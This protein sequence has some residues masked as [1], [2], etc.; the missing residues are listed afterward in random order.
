MSGAVTFLGHHG[1]GKRVSSAIVSG[2]MVLATEF[3]FA[4]SK[5]QELENLDGLHFY[6][7]RHERHTNCK[8]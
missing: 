4:A 1:S 7:V 6:L 5:V 2:Q 3:H 8:Q